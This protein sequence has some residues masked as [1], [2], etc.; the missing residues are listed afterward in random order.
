MLDVELTLE[1]IIDK[2]AKLQL[3]KSPARP[4]SPWGIPVLKELK[5]PPSSA[6]NSRK[7]F[8]SV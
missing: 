5:N 8:Y 2:L 3:N 4:P 7:F 1:D 6:K